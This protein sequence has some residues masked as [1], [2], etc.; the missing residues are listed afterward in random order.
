MMVFD[1]DILLLQGRESFSK[2]REAILARTLQLNPNV[3]SATI[4]HFFDVFTDVHTIGASKLPM[5]AKTTYVRDSYS[6]L[7]MDL[8]GKSVEI[9]LT[10]DHEINVQDSGTQKVIT[11]YRPE[12]VVVELKVPLAY[13]KLTAENLAQVPGLI[14]VV[15]LKKDLQE[16]HI[17]SLYRLGSGKLSTFRKALEQTELVGD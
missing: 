5:F 7:L 17:L 1:K 15:Q 13:A 11:A 4:I 2:N 10:I 16:N 8:K 6:L 3:P 14:E 9:Q 12:D